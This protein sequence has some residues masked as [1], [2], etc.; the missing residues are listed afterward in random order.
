MSSA[1]ADTLAAASLIIA[2]FLL[3]FALFG[4]KKWRSL[5]YTGYAVVCFTYSVTLGEFVGVGC[6]VALAVA[7]TAYV[8][9]KRFLP[10]EATE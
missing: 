3:T 8:S 5:S 2:A 1:Y 9:V 6:L 4:S 7:F 10:E